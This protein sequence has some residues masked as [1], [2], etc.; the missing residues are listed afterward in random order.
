MNVRKLTHLCLAG[1]FCTVLAACSSTPKSKPDRTAEEYYQEGISSIREGKWKVAAEAYQDLDRRHPFSPLAQQ[2]QLNLIYAHFKMEEYDDVVTDTERFL[3]LH[4]RHKH[5]AYAYYMRGLA[6]FR[7][8]TDAFRDQERSRAA[9]GALQEV[10]SRFPD[11]DYAWEASRMALVC[12]NRLA[13][14][15]LV[16]GRYY[17]DREEY[18]AAINRMRVVVENGQFQTTPYVEEALFS[19]VFANNRLGLKEDARNYAAVLGRN[20][21]EGSFYKLARDIV[22]KNDPLTLADVKK[23]RDQVKEGGVLERMF[24]GLTPG[25]PSQVE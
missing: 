7:R 24:K 22:E 20:F 5:V 2:A 8:L 25:L 16:V 17:L 15:E 18:V 9:L 21:P 4:P 1:L 23:M 12:I 14:Q 10:V 19:L 6:H 3:R 11:T 13:Q